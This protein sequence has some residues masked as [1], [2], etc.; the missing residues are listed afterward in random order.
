MSRSFTLACIQ[1][2][3]GAEL[4]PNIVAASD[5][6][7]QAAKQGAH[8]AS[9]PECAVLIEPDR[10]AL[11]Q[12]SPPEDR[13][14]ALAAFTDLAGQ[15]GLWLHIGSLAVTTGSGE[16][17]NRSFLI[18]PEGTIAARYDKI[19]MFDVDLCGNESY[20]ESDTY[21]PGTRA[22]ITDLPWGRLGLTICYDVRFPSLYTHLAR[23]GARYIAVPSAF[24]RQT[25]AAHWHVLLRAR[26]IETGSWVFAAA[27]CGEHAAGRQTYGHS[28]IVD[29]WGHVVA[30]T[31]NEPG[32][33]MAEI[34]PAQAEKARRAIPALV[35]ARPYSPAGSSGSTD[36]P[37]DRQAVYR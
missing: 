25:G 20:R 11:R 2:N 24:T 37:E 6:I 29:P 23:A 10:E 28:I 33:I 8:L 12:K 27:Q 34:D 31:G 16:L 1:L 36:M 17:A 32:L 9:L 19:H 35:N 13:H 15:T 22:V 18:S 14:P 4:A 30:E 26:A 5:L 21:R 7:H 3:A